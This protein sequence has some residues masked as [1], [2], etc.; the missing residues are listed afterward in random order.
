MT[1][2]TDDSIMTL[3]V[4][5][6]LQKGY[7]YDKKLIVDTFKMWARAYPDSGYG[8]RFSNWVFSND[9]FRCYIRLI[10]SLEGLLS[11]VFI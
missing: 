10:D 11:R 5:D 9:D 4:A 1:Y 8:V 7:E 2:P 3:A 6:V